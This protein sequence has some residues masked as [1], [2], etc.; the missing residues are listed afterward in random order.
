[1]VKAENEVTEDRGE[2]EEQE[3]E[4]DP[5]AQPMEQYEDDFIGNDTRD[6]QR[7]LVSGNEEEAS[8]VDSQ[9]R[10][11]YDEDSR[12]EFAR[13]KFDSQPEEEIP[14]DD[15]S[16]G[17]GDGNVSDLKYLQQVDDDGEQSPVADN[18]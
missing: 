12:P 10:G 8:E 14:R 18:E 5:D 16:E 3:E 2:N 1:M 6:Q 7:E 13:G 9:M 17:D 4:V 15:E 11:R